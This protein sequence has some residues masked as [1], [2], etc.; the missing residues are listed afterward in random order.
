MVSAEEQRL[1]SLIEDLHHR[2]SRDRLKNE[3]GK[4][5]NNGENPGGPYTWQVKWHNSGATSSE[6]ALLAAN[7]VGKTRTGGAEVAIHVTGQYPEWW[8]GKRFD[9]PINCIVAGPTNELTRD[10]TQCELFGMMEEG[11][12][13][14]TGMGW[15]PADCIGTYKF[16]QCGIANVLDYVRVRHVTGEWSTISFRS[17]EQGPVKFQGTKQHLIWLDEEPEDFLIYTECLTRTVDAGGILIFTRTP[18]FGMSEV[19]THFIEGALIEG[20]GIS[21]MTAT[22]ADAPHLSPEVCERILLSFPEHERATR[23]EGSPMMGSGGVFNFPDELIMCDPFE[24]PQYWRKIN[25]IDFGMNH[26]FAAA[27]IAYDAD[28]DTVYITDTYRIRNE[29]PLTHAAKIKSWGEEVPT[30]WPHDGHKR[31]FGSGV[32]LKDQ[33]VSE[34]LY[35]LEESA[36]Y[37]DE[38]GGGQPAEPWVLDVIQRAR[39][40]RFKVFR[41]LS[42]WFAEKRMYYRKDGTIIRQKDDLLSASKYGMMSL[43]FAV[44]GNSRQ[45]MQQK[46]IVDYEPAQLWTPGMTGDHGGES[47]MITFNGGY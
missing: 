26:Y 33:Y 41:H 35:M 46:A 37:K 32:Q 3:Y 21:Y 36:R 15:V 7:R 40:G 18:L 11:E 45:N 17:Y 2:V 43:R 13:K 5:W 42:E 16:R 12:K 8:K 4:P 30:A 6:R 10:T 9:H 1:A 47:D 14:P 44:S 19:V 25:G 34:G 39:T 31:D 28:R 29:V 24:V 23:T 38:V 22:W 27:Q 20:S